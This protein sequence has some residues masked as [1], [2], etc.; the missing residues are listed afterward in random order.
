MKAT[1]RE[2]LTAAIHLSRSARQSMLAAMA[3]VIPIG[4]KLTGDHGKTGEVT[5]HGYGQ[6]ADRVRLDVGG[7]AFQILTIDDVFRLNPDLGA[8]VVELKAPGAGK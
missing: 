5:A 8:E 4:S 1:R 7:S 3:E 6:S 2:H